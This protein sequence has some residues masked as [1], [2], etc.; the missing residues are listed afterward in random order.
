MGE[1]I[2]KIIVSRTD[3]EVTVALLPHKDGS[4]WSF[5]NLSKGHICP[6]KFT[7]K[8]EGMADLDVQ[9]KVLNYKVGEC[10]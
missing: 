3:G 5:V 2:E 1:D 7:S 8:E 10:K 4:G 6:C 9:P